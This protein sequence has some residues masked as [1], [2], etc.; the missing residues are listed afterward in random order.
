MEENSSTQTPCSSCQE[1]LDGWKRA[2]ADYDNLKKELAREKE[3]IRMSVK[4][5]IAFRL[6][7]IMDH[8]SQALAH[9][10]EGVSAEVK[11]WIQGLLHTRR[12]M[13]EELRG[14]GL[15][16]YASAGDLFDPYLHEAVEKRTQEGVEEGTI[17]EVQQQ[18]WR[19]QDRVVRPARVVVN[20]S[21]P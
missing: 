14:F 8:F 18:G 3:K 12:Q 10:P 17:L 20:H 11:G 2:L 21:S 4:E 5:D 9:E 1:Y 16:A 15:E 7:P 13:E 6:L 19:L